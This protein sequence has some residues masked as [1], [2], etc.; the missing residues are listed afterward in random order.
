VETRRI[1]TLDVSV[2]GLGCNNFGGRL[3]EART[4]EVIDAALVEGVT[5]LDTADNYGGSLSETFIGRALAG[6]RD[7]VVLAT[8]FGGWNAEAGRETGGS[9]A[10]VRASVEASLRRLDTDRIDLF[11]LHTPDAQT[12]IAETLATLDELVREGKVREIGCSNLT[13]A[14]LGEADAA[15]PDG[16]ARF[17]SVQNELSLLERGDLDDGLAEAARLGLAYLPYFPLASGLLTGKVRRGEPVPDGTRIAGWATDRRDATL[18]DSTF[19]RLEALERFARDRGHTLLELAFA[20][21]LAQ[22]PVASVIA[23]ATSGEQVRANVAAGE[24]RLDTDDLAAVP[25]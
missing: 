12:P 5:L 9:E 13:A 16:A 19:D 21:L 7:R 20:W 8:K 10:N 3:D 6:R 18:T 2:V 1:G 24:W 17:V 23:G 11:Q 25:G 15:V 4:R 14:Q 22:T